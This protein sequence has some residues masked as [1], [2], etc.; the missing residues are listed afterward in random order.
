MHKAIA[1][2]QNKTELKLNIL[3]AVH[4]AVAVWNSRGSAALRNCFSKAESL[5]IKTLRKIRLQ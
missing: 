3:Q 2:I 5:V 4:T 1:A